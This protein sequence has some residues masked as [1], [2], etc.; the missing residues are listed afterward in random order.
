[1]DVKI[2]QF[3][4]VG[5]LAILLA[6]CGT[7]GANTEKD[8]TGSNNEAPTSG[9]GVEDEQTSSQ[10]P[11]KLAGSIE[12]TY[13]FEGRVETAEAQ[14]WFGQNDYYIYLPNTVSTQPTKDGVDIITSKELPVS[15]MTVKVI[16]KD[17]LELAYQ[18]AKNELAKEYPGAKISEAIEK[19]IFSSEVIKQLGVKNAKMFKKVYFLEVEQKVFEITQEIFTSEE[20]EQVRFNA[21]INSMGTFSDHIAK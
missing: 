4:I 19:N 6:G 11:A 9:Q 10:P 8:T 17:S 12:L 13:D 14:L 5:T 16:S 21:M 20:F 2:K 7:N 18:S 15:T 1:M 3:V